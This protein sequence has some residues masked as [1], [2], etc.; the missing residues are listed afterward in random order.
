M[1]FPYAFCTVRGAREADS[2]LMPSPEKAMSKIMFAPAPRTPTIVPAPN[3]GWDTLTPILKAD[4][5]FPPA[6]GLAAPLPTPP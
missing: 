3:F 6:L 2:C 1:A 4:K 5:S